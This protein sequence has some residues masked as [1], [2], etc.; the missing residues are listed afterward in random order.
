MTDHEQPSPEMGRNLANI[1]V[2]MTG[3]T[4]ITDQ[5]DREQE[6]SKKVIN[7]TDTKLSQGE[8]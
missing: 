1:F 8:K 7:V 5:Q 6:R 3:E 2:E 4:S